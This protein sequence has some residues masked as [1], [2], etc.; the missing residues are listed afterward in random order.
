MLSEG[1]NLMI[2]MVQN[3][4]PRTIMLFVDAVHP[5]INRSVT[6]A[7]V[8]LTSGMRRTESMY[9]IHIF[10]LASPVFRKLVSSL[11]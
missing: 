7:I 3:P 2:R 4:K 10:P 6:A 5:K 1:V 9:W 11:R 8:T